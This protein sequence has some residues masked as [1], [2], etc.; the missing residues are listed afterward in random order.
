M[1]ASRRFFLTAAPV[2]GVA[3]ITSPQAHATT[4]LEDMIDDAVARLSWMFPRSYGTHAPMGFGLRQRSMQKNLRA[5]AVCRAQ[6]RG[7]NPSADELYAAGAEIYHTKQFNHLGLHLPPFV[8][9]EVFDTIYAAAT[10]RVA[11]LSSA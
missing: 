8:S 5:Y 10:R 9:G 7:D 1:K 3:L 4:S 2:S 11:E 6:L